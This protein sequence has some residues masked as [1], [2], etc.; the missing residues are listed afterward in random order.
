MNISNELKKY[1]EESYKNLNSNILY[2]DLN[3]ILFSAT[4]DEN[5]FFEQKKFSNEILL[6]INSWKNAS[7]KN[8]LIMIYNLYCIPIIQ[9]DTT[10]YYSQLILPLCH[11]DKLNGL[12]IFYRKEQNFIPSSAKPA[13]TTKQFVE[14]LSYVN[15]S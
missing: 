11:N 7:N 5:N 8:E 13:I 6:I 15:F 4:T 3:E 2:T 1:I 9:N 12:L 14:E 10:K